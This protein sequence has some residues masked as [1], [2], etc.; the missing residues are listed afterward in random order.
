MCEKAA[1]KGPFMLKYCLDR[2]KTQETCDKAVD[3]CLSLLTVSCVTFQ[4]G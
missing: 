4:N 2:Y 1:S 3:A